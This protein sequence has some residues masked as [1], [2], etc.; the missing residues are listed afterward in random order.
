[1]FL[2]PKHQLAFANLH[3]HYHD[4][5][6]LI[7]VAKVR[8]RVLRRAYLHIEVENNIWVIFKSMLS[9]SRV[10]QGHMAYTTQNV[11]PAEMMRQN[12]FHNK[13][14]KKFISIIR[15]W[16]KLDFHG[17]SSDM[18]NLAYIGAK[19][20]EFRPITGFVFFC[21]KINKSSYWSKFKIF[22]ANVGLIKHITPCQTDMYPCPNSS[23][24]F[25]NHL[26]GKNCAQFY[27]KLAFTS[28]YR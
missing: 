13:R 21:F 1:M 27:A 14:M 15:V 19:N 24:Y 26:L 6:L 3:K 5:A 23:T 17:Y 2:I 11:P 20:F 16:A 10:D 7:P 18:L 4:F 8:I 28:W 12:D 25:I 9:S 22:G